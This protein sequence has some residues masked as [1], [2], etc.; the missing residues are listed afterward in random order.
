MSATYDE[1]YL[2]AGPFLAWLHNRARLLAIGQGA[3]DPQHVRGTLARRLGISDRSLRRYWL[4]QDGDCKPVTSYLRGHIEDMLWREGVALW[5]VYPD[6][7][8][9]DGG[10]VPANEWCDRCEDMVTPI[11]EKG[12]LICPWCTPSAVKS[13]DVRGCFMH[14]RRNGLCRRHLRDLVAA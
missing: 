7:D 1:Q 3:K 5:E 2:P 4:S 8:G 14:R 9:D 6:A 11:W 13:C 10:P 12:E